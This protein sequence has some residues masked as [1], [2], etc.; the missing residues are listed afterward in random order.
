VILGEGLEEI[1]EAAFAECT[2]L[3]EISTPHAVKALKKAAF[4]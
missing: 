1:G 2:S 4:Y 3:H